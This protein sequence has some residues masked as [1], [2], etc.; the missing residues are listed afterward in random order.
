MKWS[1]DKSNFVYFIPGS[2]FTTKLLEVIFQAFNI[3]FASL[4]DQTGN[5]FVSNF[6]E[7]FG[8]LYGILLT[9]ILVR[10][11]EQL[12]HIDR[13]FDREADTVKILYADILFL[14]GKN[15][16]IGKNVITLLHNYVQHV[17]DNYPNE[18]KKVSDR[19]IAGG[20]T[21]QPIMQRFID[22]IGNYLI[23]M[24]NRIMK[25]K[26]S[27][28]MTI[29]S[30]DKHIVDNK[31]IEQI[32]Q[33]DAEMTAEITESSDER[34]KGDQIL[35]DI[36]HEIRSLLN[37]NVMRAK[38]SEF[39][40]KEF[41][42][43]LNE[44]IDIRGDRIGL[45]SQ[46]LFDTLRLV[47]LVTSIIYVVPFYFVSLSPFPAG[48][49]DDALIIGVTLLVIFIYLTIEDFDE[50]FKGTWKISNESW[51]HILEEMDSPGRKFELENLGKEKKL[52]K[53]K[54]QK[55]S[56]EKTRVKKSGAK[57]G[58]ATT[59]VSTSSTKTQS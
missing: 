25:S 49:L 45:A 33:P 28:N 51:Q 1:I 50:P 20:N 34:I 26:K 54:R 55:D 7:W 30:D 14:Q 47:V 24:G 12:D 35:Q 39:L 13:E 27:D 32:E 8:V 38:A 29:E 46:R 36:R 43:R 6:I 19:R 5:W 22:S 16:I 40:V 42:H 10:V 15:A 48:L 52:P 11:W 56:I 41:F 37:S 18:I 3:D 17:L 9:L 59:S 58:A 23:K 4:P 57:S 31:I 53:P 21:T 2:I 44:L